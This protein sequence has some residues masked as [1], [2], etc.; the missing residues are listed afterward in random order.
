[1]YYEINESAA[2]L[3]HDNMS[4]RDYIPNSA[5]SEYRAAVDRAAAVLEE[6]KAKC[7]T[8]AQR[9]RAEYYF[10]PLRQEAG[11]GHQPGKRH[12]HSMP[13]CTYCRAIFL[14]F[15]SAQKGKAGCRL[16]SKPRQLRESRPLSPPAQNRAHSRRQV[17]ATRKRCNTC[18]QEVWQG[19]NL[20]TLK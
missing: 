7:K 5:T 9:E 11:T 12:R 20:P 2:R 1:M 15:P 10:R 4:M 17:K 14:Q 18:K 3:A 13:V 19:W 6:V 16:G 8:Q